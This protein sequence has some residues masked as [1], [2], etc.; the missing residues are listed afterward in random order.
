MHWVVYYLST[1]ILCVY[2]IEEYRVRSNSILSIDIRHVAIKV[3]L[4]IMLNRRDIWWIMEMII[5]PV[6]L[7]AGAIHLSQCVELNA[8]FIWPVAFIDWQIVVS[9]NQSMYGLAW[10]ASLTRFGFIDWEMIVI[11]AYD[12]WMS[13]IN[14]V[15][16]MINIKAYLKLFFSMLYY[17]QIYR[18]KPLEHRRRL[19]SHNLYSKVGVQRIMNRPI[20]ISSIRLPN[21]FLVLRTRTFLSINM[22]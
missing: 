16:H 5:W 14:L 18:L 1:V 7:F 12:V 8:L 13:F 10:L 22:Y 21:Y 4:M 15:G 2:F 3:P 20:I 11:F 19:S 6:A 17:N 9:Q